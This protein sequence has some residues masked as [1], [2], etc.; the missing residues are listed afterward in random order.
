MKI[1]FLLKNANLLRN[2]IG[3]FLLDI[4]FIYLF[5]AIPQGPQYIPPALLPNLATSA[6]WP[7]RGQNT[8]NK[9]YQTL[10]IM[11][12]NGK[13]GHLVMFRCQLNSYTFV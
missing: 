8:A 7:S 10:C 13:E 5:N 3:I 6:S 11:P 1:K 2:E 9:L 12:G 4:F